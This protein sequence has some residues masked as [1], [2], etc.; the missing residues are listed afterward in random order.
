MD[1]ILKWYDTNYKDRLAKLKTLPATKLAA[2]IPFFGMPPMPAVTY[3]NF[4]TH[5]CAH[6]RGQLCSYVR[7]MGGKVPSVYGGSADEPF[8]M[9]ANA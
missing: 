2:P 4:M 3:L 1:E 7:P 9:P 5:H 6:H 8:E